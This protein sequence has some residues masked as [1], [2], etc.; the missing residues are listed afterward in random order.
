MSEKKGVKE[1]RKRNNKTMKYY[2]QHRLTEKTSLCLQKHT[3]TNNSLQFPSEMNTFQTNYDC[4]DR[5]SYMVQQYTYEVERLVKSPMN[6]EA[7]NLIK[8][9]KDF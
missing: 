4:R 7:Q 1:D 3:Y 2:F 5:L 8:K 6:H 9:L